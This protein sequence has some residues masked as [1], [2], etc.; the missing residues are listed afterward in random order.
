MNFTL[1]NDI[2]CIINVFLL[3]DCIFIFLPACYMI[4]INYMAQRTSLQSGRDQRCLMFS[5]C[6]R[7]ILVIVIGLVIVMVILIVLVI[8]FSIVIVF[9]IVLV[10]V[11]VVVGFAFVVTGYRSCIVVGSYS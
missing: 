9:V 10:I 1:S 3:P 5:L 4:M 11:V 7:I 2:Q 6:A 8:I